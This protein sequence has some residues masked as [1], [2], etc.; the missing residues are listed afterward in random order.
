MGNN[1][2]TKILDLRQ[3]GYSINKIQKELACSKSLISYHIN[4]HNLGGVR[5]NIVKKDKND[6][7]KNIS[8]ETIEIIK[9]LRNK[10]KLYKEI[11][12]I[13]KVSLDKISKICK[14]FNITKL[15]INFKY[16]WIENTDNQKKLI[17]EYYKGKNFTEIAKILLIDRKKVSEYLEYLGLYKI[18]H[19]KA[20]KQTNQER[21]KSMVKH[22]NNCRRKRRMLLIDYKGSKCQNCNYNNC[23]SA[24]HFHHIDPMKKDFTIGGRNYSFERMKN[25]VDKCVLVCSNCHTEIHEELRNNGYS[26]ILNKILNIQKSVSLVD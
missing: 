4:K 5:C 3:K 6:F 7:L 17:E 22:V 15:Y 10:N 23:I 9:E 20:S 26:D 11:S 21:K 18:N 8:I 19:P 25:E 13:T 14:I 2:K 16:V 12:Q 24:L 1:L